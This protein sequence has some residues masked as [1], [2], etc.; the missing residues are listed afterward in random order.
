M[1]H[2]LQ[3]AYDLYLG[4]LQKLQAEIVETKKVLNSMAKEMGINPQYEEVEEKASNL[5]AVEMDEYVNKLPGTG[6]RMFLEKR[7]RAATWPEI[8]DGLKKGGFEWAKYG[9]EKKVR[10][11]IQK[12]TLTFK[13]VKANDAFGLKEWYGEVEKVKKAKEDA[14]IAES[15]TPVP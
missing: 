7:S 12:N 14:S 6:V 3:A 13:Y 9:G 4:K 11:T 2:A 1:A 10:L 15:K 8:V 5:M